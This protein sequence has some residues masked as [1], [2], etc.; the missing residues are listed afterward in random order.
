MVLRQDLRLLVDKL[1]ESIENE[2]CEL[3]ETVEWKIWKDA[4]NC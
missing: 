1:D 4:V 3:R 2:V